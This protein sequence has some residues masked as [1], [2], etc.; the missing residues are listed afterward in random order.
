MC[1]KILICTVK[2]SKDVPLDIYTQLSTA[3]HIAPFLPRD[4]TISYG[5]GTVDIGR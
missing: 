1:D 4:R 5:I 3:K 2:F